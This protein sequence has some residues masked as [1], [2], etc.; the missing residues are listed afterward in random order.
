YH[1]RRWRV[2]D[3]RHEATAFADE[4]A[5]LLSFDRLRR[6][7]GLDRERLAR[8]LN[9]ELNVLFNRHGAF[10]RWFE[11]RHDWFGPADVTPPHGI[12]R[13]ERT[14]AIHHGRTSLAS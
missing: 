1:V 12:E 2:F 9:H 5:D 8:R 6:L 14:S 13:P 10:D 11:R 3:E 7:R 4:V